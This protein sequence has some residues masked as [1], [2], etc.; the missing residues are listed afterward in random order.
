MIIALLVILGLLMAGAAY[1]ALAG[2]AARR[3]F[4][5]PFPAP[6]PAGG[7]GRAPAPST[8]HRRRLGADGGN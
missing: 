6:G 5:A 1:E 2:A 3:R 8:L 4:P 7:G